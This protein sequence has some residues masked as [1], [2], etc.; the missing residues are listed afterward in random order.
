MSRQF[1]VQTLAWLAMACGSSVQAE[2]ARWL[3]DTPGT[4]AWVLDDAMRADDESLLLVE[5]LARG[6]QTPGLVVLAVRDD[7][8]QG[9]EARFKAI[10]STGKVRELMLAARDT[11]ME[12]DNG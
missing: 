11:H 2:V 7:E 10:R 3:S 12:A 6:A 5:R 9:F 1:L 4:W 8:R